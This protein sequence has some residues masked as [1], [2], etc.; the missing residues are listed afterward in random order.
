MADDDCG[1]SH[2]MNRAWR[3]SVAVQPHPRSS[4]AGIVDALDG[5]H[6]QASRA[7]GERPEGVTHAGLQREPGDESGCVW[8]AMRNRWL[9]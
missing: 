4:M 8:L 7:P 2:S 1:T 5:C 3:I 9:T 6:G